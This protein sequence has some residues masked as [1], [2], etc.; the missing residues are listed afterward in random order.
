MSISTEERRIVTVLFADMA[1]STALGEELDPEEMRRLLT[2]YYAIARDCVTQ[3]G[4]TIEK[5]IGDAVMAVFGLPTAHGDDPDRAVAAAVAMR[6]HLR[7]D[8]QL[9]DRFAIRFGVSTGEVVASRDQSAGDFLI[10]GDAT[11]VAARLQQ[12]AEPWSILVSDRT[13]R[14]STRSFDFGDEVQVAAKG[15]SVPV[16]AREVLGPRKAKGQVYVRLPLVGR[17][18]DLAQLQLV[19]RRS[20]SER[21]PSMVSVIA[22]A[23]TGKTRLVE[24]FMDWLPSLAPDAVVATAQCL[25]YGQ[26]LTY[27]PMRQ[28]LFTLT[29]SSEDAKPAEVRDAIGAWLQGLGVEN[30]ERDSM[31]LAA[32]IGEAGTEGVDKDQLFAAWRSA[33]EAV[34]RRAPLVIVFEDLH[35]SSD[36]LLDLAEFVM[37]PRG[38]AAVLMI[39]LARPELL[40]RRPAW[41]GGRRNHLSMALEP[42]GATAIGDLVRHLLDTDAPEVIELVAER[43]EGNPFYA[44]EL[45]R[46]YLEQ[47][48]LERLPDTV[49]ATVL[50]R[51]DLLPPMERRVLQL[52]SVFGRAF[53]AT[54]VAALETGLTEQVAQLCDN[55]AD[56]DLIRPADSD[57]FAFRHILI[58]E[59]AYNTLPRTERARLHAEAGRW[60]ESASE[61]REVAVAEILAFHYREAAVLSTALDPTA[62]ATSRAKESAAHWL[63]KAADVAA[64]AAA[65]PEAVRHIRG[66][67]DF[68]A[69]TLRPS[70]H[71][72]I[73][74]MTGGDSG[75]E[76]YR[77]AFEGYQECDAP[78]DDQLRALAGM[79]MV[80]TRW[81]G[82][83][84]DRPNEA[85]MD[86]LRARGRALLALASQPRSI[87]RFLAADAFYPFW[88]QGLRQP[89]AEEL[90]RGEADANRAL[91]IALE[92]DDPDL[93]SQALDAV[94]GAAQSVNDYV[95][96]RETS[97]RRIGFQDRLGLYERLD[98]HS[99]VA[100][101]SYLMGDLET[102]DRDSAEM[103]ARLL[104]G[105]AP[106]PALHLFAWRALTLYTLGRWDEAASA[107]WRAIESWHDAGS[108]AAGYGLRGFSVG[109]DIGRARGDS[110]LVGAATDAMVSVLS[111]FPADHI[112]KLW[113]GYIRGESGLTSSDPYLTGQMPYESVEKRLCLASDQREHLP[114]EILEAGLDR[115]VEVGVPLLE[116]QVRRARALAYRDATELDRALEIWDRIG[117]VP[118]QGRARAERGL[119]AG[120][121][122]ET[123]AGLAILKT[124]GD[125]NYVDRF[126]DWI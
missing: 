3:H 52:G 1:G 23:G 44:G 28:V 42:L 91:Q 86:A 20:I 57:R 90:A 124:L 102:A 59:V 16:A 109:L 107:F 73:G 9:S 7:A 105:Q 33:L 56:R 94:S 10:T 34:A 104:P 79:L 58:Q 62:E 69:P 17:E 14:A 47:G 65:T 112:N 116:A 97:I 41:G 95:K 99:M 2:R 87:A 64:A 85:W 27:W 22:P 51:L 126:A 106:Y 122:A 40:D 49:Q 55:L 76:A 39:V 68:V 63:L 111:R 117:A 50:A 66:A 96:A 4:G 80:A 89:T 84:G 81:S 88:L 38:D 123:Q 29:G 32:T 48:S 30:A 8:A 113:L 108:H 54:G 46:S 18:N 120:D 77:L 67:M 70:L 119:I 60:V 110:R 26:Q 71:E 125:A 72:R 25:P 101:M 15:K 78:T 75:L 61:G 31:L 45:V 98:A 19:A 35:W 11:N 53:R 118:Y 6:E 82:S 103:V 43:S 83:V 13:V 92:L 115:A 24:E 37:Q 100:W 121:P 36:S 12:A 5:F 74:D 21:R 93:A 114:S